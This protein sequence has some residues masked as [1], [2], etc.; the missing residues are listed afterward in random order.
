MKQ[1]VTKIIFMLFLCVLFY[2]CRDDVGG[3]G[4]GSVPYDPDK[5][6]LL[7]SFTPTTGGMATR[8]ILSGENLGNDPKA[9]KVYFNDKQA[10]VIGCDKGKVLAITPRQ[11]GDDCT[12]SVV[13]GNDSIVYPDKFTYVTRT[14]VTTL[15][16][17]KG[18]TTFKA[19]PFP[20][21][22]FTVLLTLRLMMNT[23]SSFPIIALRITLF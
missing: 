14:I 11:P 15:V 8:M 18:T 22:R 17:Q 19:G 4:S 21:L 23:T 16:G 2:S 10:P 7:N 6:V 12:I 13:I 5:P 3:G 9:I 20:K 1:N